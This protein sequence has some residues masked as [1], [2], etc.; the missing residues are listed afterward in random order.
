MTADQIFEKKR[1]CQGYEDGIKKDYI[2]L[3]YAQSD[4][5]IM[6]SFYSNK[7]NSCVYDVVL[8]QSNITDSVE[9]LIDVLGNRSL[10]EDYCSN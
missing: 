4:I 3:G 10:A 9:R 2:G 6:D 1:E 7:L 8:S 5:S